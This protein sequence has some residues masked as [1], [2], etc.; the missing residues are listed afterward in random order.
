MRSRV[1]LVTAVAYG[2][3]KKYFGLSE[4]QIGSFGWGGY[5]ERDQDA[6][7]NNASVYAS[8]PSTSGLPDGRY[9]DLETTIRLQFRRRVHWLRAAG[10]IFAA[11]EIGDGYAVVTNAG[12]KAKF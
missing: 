9:N 3:A 1:Y 10:R 8:L 6:N 5:V 2:I 7:E 12:H 4:P 11:N